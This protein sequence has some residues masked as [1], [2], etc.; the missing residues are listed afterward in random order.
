[1]SSFGVPRV[2]GLLFWVL[3]KQGYGRDEA[4]D[5]VKNSL[6]VASGSWLELANNLPAAV[7]SGLAACLKEKDSLKAS[8]LTATL[9]VSLWF[10]S[11]VFQCCKSPASV[12]HA[13]PV[14]LSSPST[15]LAFPTP[16]FPCQMQYPSLPLVDTDSS[17]GL[18]PNV[19][20]SYTCRPDGCLVSS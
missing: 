20:S 1:M 7:S 16:L 18:L 3:M 5:D 8:A 12:F 14:D 4:N 10:S 2:F 11:V 17:V 19:L 6:L 15:K 9:Q 13:F